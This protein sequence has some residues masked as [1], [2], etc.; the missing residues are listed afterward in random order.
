MSGYALAVGGG[1]LCIDAVGSVRDGD[2]IATRVRVTG[3]VEGER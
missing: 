3:L 1:P 2:M